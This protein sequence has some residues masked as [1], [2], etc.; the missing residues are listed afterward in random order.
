MISVRRRKSYFAIFLF[1]VGFLIMAYPLISDF[2]NQMISETMVSEYKSD[3]SSKSAEELNAEYQ[4]A[5]EYNEQHQFNT[6]LDVFSGGGE[7][8]E[9]YMSL[10]N[11]SNDG[12]MGYIEIPRISQRIVI[13]QALVYL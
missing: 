9:M 10:L 12:V 2:W 4:K 1:F 5:K 13:Y 7:Q 3:I 8:E 6:V 11:P